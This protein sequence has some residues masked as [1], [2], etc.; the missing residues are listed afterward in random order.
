MILL[1]HYRYGANQVLWE[2]PAGTIEKE[3]T[4]SDCAKRELEEETGY[5]ARRWKKLMSCFASPGFNT[6]VIHCYLAQ[7][8]RKVQVQLEDDDVLEMRVVSIKE[9]KKMILQKQIRDAK[10]LVALFYFFAHRENH[11]C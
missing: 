4:A 10:S 5:Q 1:R 3:E 6:E 7:D 2:I 9:V 11:E 8:L